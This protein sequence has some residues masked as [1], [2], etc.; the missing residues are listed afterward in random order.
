M[1]NHGLP[2]GFP[3][4]SVGKSSMPEIDPLV[5]VVLPPVTLPAVIFPDIVA[6]SLVVCASTE[7]MTLSPDTDR[8]AA[9]ARMADIA[10][11]VVGEYENSL[12]ISFLEEKTERSSKGTRMVSL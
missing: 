9:P 2:Y 6:L 1:F 4:G 5:P 8:V 11:I 12:V 10:N 7:P 3:S